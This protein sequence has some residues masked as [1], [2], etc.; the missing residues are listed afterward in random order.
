[1]SAQ[2]LPSLTDL[3][4]ADLRALIQAAQE[5]LLSRTGEHA[6]LAAAATDAYRVARYTQQA[7][8]C[9]DNRR[10][11]RLVSLAWRI[12]YRQRPYDLGWLLSSKPQGA[13]L[14][15]KMLASAMQD[16][17]NDAREAFLTRSGL[18]PLTPKAKYDQAEAIE[19]QRGEEAR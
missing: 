3:S 13:M 1:M 19:L 6:D 14:A 11:S 8:V 10:A 16:Q 12:A 15:V 18:L 4:D 17:A 7:A 2:D 5:D 9:A